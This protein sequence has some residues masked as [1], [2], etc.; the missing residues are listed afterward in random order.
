[1]IENDITEADA[2]KMELDYLSKRGCVCP[3]CLSDEIEPT[4]TVQTDG[5]AAWQDMRC[6]MCGLTWVDQYKLNGITVT[7]YED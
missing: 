3:H 1:M 4:G 2:T 7:G 5:G 6:G